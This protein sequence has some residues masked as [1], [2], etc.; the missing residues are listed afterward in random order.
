VTIAVIVALAY[1]AMWALV[2][3]VEPRRGEMTV[4]VPLD[5]LDAKPPP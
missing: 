4:P 5:G 1:A 3:L 2:M